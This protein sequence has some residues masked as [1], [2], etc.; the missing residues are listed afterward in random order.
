MRVALFAVEEA[1]QPEGAGERTVDRLVEHQVAG[2]AGTEAAVGGGLL[3]EFAFDALE[4]FRQRIDLAL[5][6]QGDALL[7]VVL[8]GDAEAFLVVAGRRPHFQLLRA[9][10]DAQRDADH[11]DPAAAF[12]AHHQHRLALVE[13]P[14]RRAFLAEVDHRHPAGHRLVQQAHDEAVGLGGQ[15]AESGEQ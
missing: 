6:L 2:Q 1:A 7:A 8:A 14:R 13:G 5:V 11:G 4:V 15:G 9:G 12:L 10:L 3:G